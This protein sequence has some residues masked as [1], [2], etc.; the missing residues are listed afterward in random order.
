MTTGRTTVLEHVHQSFQG[1]VQSLP[2]YAH[3]LPFFETLFTLQEAGVAVAS[4]DPAPLPPDTR[5]K[6][7]KSRLPLL[8]R[9][10]IP[11]DE[12]AAVSL[13]LSICREAETA[14][15]QLAEGAAVILS[16]LEKRS[17]SVK[18]GLRLFMGAD[19]QGIHALSAEL[20][21]DASILSFYLYHGTWPSVACQ[22]ARIRNSHALDDIHWDQ[23]SCPVCGSPPDLAYL[24]ENGERRLICGFCRHQWPLQ[25]IRCPHCGNQDSHSAIFFFSDTEPAYR[26]YTCK[27]CKMYLKTVDTRRLT[28]PFYPPLE[29][30]VTAHLDLKTQG[31]GF[32]GQHQ[33][34]P[35]MTAQ[36]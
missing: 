17:G 19:H 23:G 18:R 9:A 26:I 33:C 10:R 3:I 15:S 28:R 29:G 25:R 35:E 7:I 32:K 12:P 24:S 22:V 34:C 4:P 16:D 36:S 1:A 20:N 13:L 2:A 21:M 5:K 11:Y 27:A 14:T 8:D 30:I 31:L 6:G